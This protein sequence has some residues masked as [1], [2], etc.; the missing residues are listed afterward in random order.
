MRTLFLLF[1]LACSLPCARSISFSRRG[2][3]TGSKPPV[4]AQ[5]NQRNNISISS[6]SRSSNNSTSSSSIGGGNGSN[7]D[8]SSNSS[9]V[10]S[11]GRGEAAA[12]GMPAPRPRS[13]FNT[14]FVEFFFRRCLSVFLSDPDML[15]IAAKALSLIFWCYTLLSILGTAGFDVK[16]LL[17]LVSISLVTFGFAAKDIISNT[18]CGVLILFTR[19][20]KRG[21][22][23]Q[24]NGQRGKVISVDLRYV[25]LQNLK[26]KGAVLLPLSVVYSSTIVVEKE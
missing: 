2:P 17:S 3:S 4:A 20:F 12:A 1:L 19:P 9:S 21:S 5:H 7:S 16:P 22:I 18:L 26:D 13:L 15:R 8:S 10:D 24:I 25:R 11:E 14:R 6:S 23:I